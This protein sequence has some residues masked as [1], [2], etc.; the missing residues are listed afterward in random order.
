MVS[1]PGSPR[2]EA[3][4]AAA[5]APTASAPFDEKRDVTT[6]TDQDS[7]PPLSHSSAEQD[8]TQTNWSQYTLPKRPWRRRVTDFGKIMEARYRGNGLPEDPYIVQWLD[9]DPE[10]PMSYSI[11]FKCVMTF[12]LAFM[13]LCVSLASSA[14]TGAAG[15]LIPEFHCSDEVFLLGLSLM[16]LGFAVGPLLWAPLAEA[17]SRRDILLIALAFYVMWTAVCATAQ[18]ITT[19]I[20]LRFLCGTFGSAAFV[21][22]AGQLSDMWEA[23]YRGVAQAV[24]S[25]APFLGPTIGPTIGGFLSP[26]AGWRWLF[27]F[28]ALYAAI[29]TFLG[30]V[31]VPE[32]YAPV[33]LRRRARLLSKVTGKTYMTKI[34]IEQPLV[35]KN[36]VKRSLSRPWA[37]LFREPIVLLLSIYMSVIYGTLYLCFAA[38]PIIFQK[39]Y[40]WNAGEEGLA[41]LGIML[42]SLIGTA[43]IV[44]DNKRYARIHAAHGGFAPPEARLPPVIVGGVVTIVGLAWFAG[45]ADPSIHFIVPILASVPFGIGFMLIFMCCTNYLIDSYVIYSASV[46]AG[47]SILRSTFGA[48]FP[49]FTTYMYDSLG[50]HWA[51]AVPGFIALAC[52]P[53]PIFFYRYGAK[54]R[55]RC[56]YSAEAA[57][58]LDSLKSDLER[59][60]SRASKAEAQVEADAEAGVG[61]AEVGKVGVLDHQGRVS[62]GVEGDEKEMDPEVDRDREHEQ[63]VEVVRHGSVNVNA[64]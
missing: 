19:L 35:F 8:P 9:H 31:F 62:V 3:V 15:L 5:A 10:N 27:G 24:F 14:Y 43:L 64:A 32:T 18:N 33:L 53:F 52:F 23:K 34:D 17:V 58:Y 28:L 63:E 39:G 56:K 57:R 61:E 55:R 13:T 29:L 38:F 25:A 7:Q 51:S 60:R 50:L 36:V 20:V 2:S 4:P 42:G 46:M 11:W 26:A 49:L 48:V 45:T 44:F 47:N 1:T 40:G 59:Q 37:L 6:T 21:I 41:F 22:P 16:V 12:L 54:I 30:V